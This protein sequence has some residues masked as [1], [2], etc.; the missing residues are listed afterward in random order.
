MFK[1]EHRDIFWAFLFGFCCRE[2]VESLI[3]KHS[4]ARSPI[5]TYA[6]EEETLGDDGHAAHR[7]KRVGHTL[8]MSSHT[9]HKMHIMLMSQMRVVW[10]YYYHVI[11]PN[12][13]NSRHSHKWTNRRL[14]SQCSATSM[15]VL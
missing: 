14:L 8:M 7:G 9:F 3:H 13:S 4:Y 2:S 15:T 12:N 11:L 10:C 6:G 1:S 5:R